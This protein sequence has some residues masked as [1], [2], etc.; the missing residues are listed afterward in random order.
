M[1]TYRQRAI[2]NLIERFWIEHWTSPTVRQIADEL[3]FASTASVAG[4]LRRMTE[5]GILESHR[6]SEHRV[7]YRVR[8]D[9]AR[10]P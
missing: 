1:L 7:L 8:R 10:A 2:C 3:G 4:H 6:P 9:Y 5:R